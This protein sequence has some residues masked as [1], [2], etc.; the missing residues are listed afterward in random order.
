MSTAKSS[1]RLWPDQPIGQKPV[2]FAWIIPLVLIQ[3]VMVS[4]RVLDVGS[5]RELF[6]DHLLV[7]RLTGARL[8]SPW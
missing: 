4:S 7:D 1:G 5:R 8:N 2:R 3:P 6:V